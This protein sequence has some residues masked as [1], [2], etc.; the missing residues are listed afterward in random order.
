VNRSWLD[1]LGG[2]LSDGCPLPLG[3]PFTAAQARS[4]GV[5]RHSLDAL[6]R[7][8]LIRRVLH[9]VYAVS[10][11]PDDTLMRAK[12]LALVVPE[13][14]VVTDRTAA[15]LHGVDI[16]PRSAV[17]GPPPLDVAHTEESRVRRPGVDGRRRG[18]MSSDITYIH[19]V[20]VTTGLRTSLDLGR[21]LWRFDALAAIDGFLALGVPHELIAAEI[22]RFRGYRGVRQLRVLAPLGDGRSESAGESALRL[23]WYDAGLP[24]PDLQHWICSDDGAAIFRLDITDPET[25]YAAEYDGEEF[26][27]SEEDHRHDLARRQWIAEQRAW[28][29]DPFTKADVYSPS[30]DPILQLQAGFA[31]ARRKVSLWTPRRRSRAIPARIE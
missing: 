22:G 20:R 4:L 17:L 9:E 7:A 16:L 5:T 10:Q 2:F 21:L 24:K 23:H 28:T 25:R 3:D 26:H 14:A 15:W 29:I 12:A 6:L 31:S 1:E 19:G 8:G 11:A 13:A 18:L 30:A 27:T